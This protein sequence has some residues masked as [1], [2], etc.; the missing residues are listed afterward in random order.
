MRDGVGEGRDGV[1]KRIADDQVG[2]IGREGREAEVDL[3]RGVGVS[4]I[5]HQDAA[6]G[7]RERAGDNALRAEVQCMKSVGED[8]YIREVMKESKRVNKGREG[9]TH[10]WKASIY[11]LSSHNK[12]SDRGRD[13]VEGLE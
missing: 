12:V 1:V 6:E 13:G 8:K 5:V 7:G 2:E 11:N 3:A 9:R 10:R 4:A